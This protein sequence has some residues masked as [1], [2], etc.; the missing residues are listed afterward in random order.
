MKT[1]SLITV[2]LGILGALLLT[3]YGQFILIPGAA[4]QAVQVDGTIRLLSGFHWLY[5]Y[6]AAAILGLVCVQ[7]VLFASWKLLDQIQRDTIFTAKAFRW[8]DTVIWATAAA[9]VLAG[10]VALQLAA[11]GRTGASI[12]E[13]GEFQAMMLCVGVG[14]AFGLLVVLLR[15]LLRKAVDLKTEIAEVI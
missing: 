13:F 10:G 14:V 15:G 12:R 8:V 3:L 5:V 4:P 6:M 7:V 9:V 11:T 1:I 2:R